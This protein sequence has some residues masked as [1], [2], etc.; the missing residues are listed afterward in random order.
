MAC[1]LNVCYHTN[2]LIHFN[3]VELILR[4][5]EIMFEEIN[6]ELEKGT[7]EYLT[8]FLDHPIS[9]RD[10]NRFIKT[11][12]RWIRIQKRRFRG[13]SSN[14]GVEIITR[15][16]WGGY[17]RG[18]IKVSSDDEYSEYI[19]NL[20]VVPKKKEKSSFFA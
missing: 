20:V 11:K 14:I 7:N 8:I 6:L 3:F 4:K 12:D 19:I 16:L 18:K 17:H 2:D 9:Y 13:T 1:N 5:E 15:G 10:I